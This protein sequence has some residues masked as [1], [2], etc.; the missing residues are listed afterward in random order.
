MFLVVVYIH[1][2]HST[3]ILLQC[4]RIMKL[5]QVQGRR[6]CHANK[7][8]RTDE[9]LFKFENTEQFGA[10]KQQTMSNLY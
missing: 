7:V 6:S 10:K 1:C 2:L 8:E 4:L 5:I 3:L 9:P